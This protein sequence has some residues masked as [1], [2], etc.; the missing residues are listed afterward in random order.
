VSPTNTYT[1]NGVDGATFTLPQGNLSGS[2][3]LT[4]HLSKIKVLAFEAQ[5]LEFDPYF[6]H[7]TPSSLTFTSNR[8]TTHTMNPNAKQGD[9]VPYVGPSSR[10]VGRTIYRVRHITHV[11]FEVENSFGTINAATFPTFRAWA[12]Y[13][14]PREEANLE[15]IAE[16]YDAIFTE[17]E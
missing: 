12:E 1:K 15:A 14:S 2:R 3:A 16:C 8:D 4:I 13:V 11:E 5:D 7:P 6:S 17:D 10:V 9:M